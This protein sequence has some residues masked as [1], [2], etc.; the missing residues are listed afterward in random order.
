MPIHGNGVDYNPTAFAG[1]RLNRR[2]FRPARALVLMLLASPTGAQ[3][4][5]VA[6]FFRNPE[7]TQMR[8]SPDGEWV[9]ALTSVN[10]RRNIAVLGVDDRE[11]VAI[12][13]AR[14][15]D[16]A[17]FLW[18]DNERLV[19]SVDVDG[20][21]A[22][23]LYGIDRDG[24]DWRELVGPTDGIQIFPR[25]VVVLDRLKHDPEHI[26]V[27]DNE[28]RKLYPD[29][30]RLN[31][32]TGRMQRTVLN[33]GFVSEWITDHDGEV[34]AGIGS[35]D[36]PREL[37]V[38]VVYRDSADG[39]FRVLTAFHQFDA[40]GW[41]PIAFTADNR[42]L[43][44][45]SNVGRDT[46]A[47]AIYD[48][49][50]D[51]L[52]ET[53][54]G[55]DLVDIDEIV[56]SPL[57]QRLLAVRYELERPAHEALD[58]EWRVL[59]ETVDEALPDTVNAVVSISDDERRLLVLA[60]SDTDPG[61]FYLLDRDRGQLRYYA[62]RMPWLDPQTMAEMQ[63]V[64]IAARD[65]TEL[66]GYLTLPRDAPPER[67]PLILHPHGGPYGVRDH[68]GFDRHVQFLASRG[69]A[70]LQVNYRGSGGYG[71]RFMD[72]AWQ[73]WGLAMQ[74]DLTDAVSWAVREGIVDADRVCIYGASYGGY[75][76]MAGITATPELYR[77][78]VNYV[79]VVDLIELY[80]YWRT[81]PLTDGVAAWFRRAIGDPR[82]DR[83]RLEATSPVNELEGLAIPLFIVH[84]RRD[85]RVP[86]AQ[87]EM[88]TR[89]LRRLG[90][91]YEL[92]IKD[93][94]GHGF[95]KQESNF[96]LYTRLEAFFAEHL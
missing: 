77:C 33:P 74:D 88:L 20:N 46:Q 17:D 7:F 49:A 64:T 53:I 6:D 54:F 56:L 95:Q 52:G 16:I 36:D 63:P 44:V 61:S 72:I 1:A 76:T 80:D 57:D 50:T 69:Y 70:V 18:V 5:S 78:A 41:T 81:G 65:G 71:K 32:H 93:D 22:Y 86:V 48:P 23:G 39:S 45:R 37:T 13:D 15:T 21:E 8:L 89:A 91:D 84:G 9:A 12:T 79:G 59:R 83:E 73:Q 28:R 87:A 51:S 4:P 55:N 90:I 26:L 25:Q 42:R 75:A 85:P 62:S 43:Y 66:H 27:S 35:T 40:H 68:W 2:V 94:E 38:Q 96:E 67:L 30:Y 14:R 60:S 29:V 11:A 3:P 24:S 34:R 47:L 10:G 58:P 31:V 82:S 19:Y 92:L